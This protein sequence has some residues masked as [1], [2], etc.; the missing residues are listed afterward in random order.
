M[1]RVKCNGGVDRANEVEVVLQLVA[2]PHRGS[3]NDAEI[4]G[5][6]QKLETK[7]HRSVSLNLASFRLVAV[8]DWT[9]CVFSVLCLF[10]HFRNK[11][12]SRPNLYIRILVLVGKFLLQHFVERT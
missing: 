3:E 9:T 6:W 1:F 2:P 4:F 5:G 8:V 12:S 11:A 7:P 10:L